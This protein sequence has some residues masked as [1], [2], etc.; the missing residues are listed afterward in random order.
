MT[1]GQSQLLEKGLMKFGARQMIC[2]V[3]VVGYQF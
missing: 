1:C 3:V 2:L